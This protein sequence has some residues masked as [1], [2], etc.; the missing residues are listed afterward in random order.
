MSLEST[1]ERIAAALES[2]DKTLAYGMQEAETE[3]AEEDKAG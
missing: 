3:I 2:I 1:L